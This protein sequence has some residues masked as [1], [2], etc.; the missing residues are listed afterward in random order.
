MGIY[1]RFYDAADRLINLPREERL[2]S[3]VITGG[4]AKRWQSFS[5]PFQTNENTRYMRIWIHSMSATRVS[6]YLDDLEIV[7]AKAAA[8]RLGDWR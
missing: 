3:I 1:A 2:K 5:K 6:A 7:E 4:D 8:G